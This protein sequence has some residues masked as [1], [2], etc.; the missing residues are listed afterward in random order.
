MGD[1]SNLTWGGLALAPIILLIIEGL[2][3]AGMP[4]SFAPIAN[5]W[6]SA[7]FQAAVFVLATEYPTAESAT[8]AAVQSLALFLTTAGLYDRLQVYFSKR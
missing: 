5:M 3:R 7:I 6:L 8:L 1:S 4:A 2:K